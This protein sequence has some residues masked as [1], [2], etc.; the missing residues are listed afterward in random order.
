[1]RLLSVEEPRMHCT[2]QS[3]EEFSGERDTS[4]VKKLSDDGLLQGRADNN[5]C[6]YRTGLPNHKRKG[7]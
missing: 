1:M 6:Y 4:I 2:D 3:T 5:R 7:S